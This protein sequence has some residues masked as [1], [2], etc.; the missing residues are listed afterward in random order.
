M[1]LEHTT[2]FGISQFYFPT[3]TFTSLCTLYTHIHAHCSL[4][5]F[6]VSCSIELVAR[7]FLFPF[8]IGLSTRSKSL[9]IIPSVLFNG[10]S[11]LLSIYQMYQ[12]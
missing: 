11:I 10:Y 3:L 1:I 4:Y 12:I 7:P 8:T 9:L 2:L 6:V 5:V